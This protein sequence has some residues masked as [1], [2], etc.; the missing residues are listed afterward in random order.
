MASAPA[1]G[2]QLNENTIQS[3]LVDHITSPT[4]IRT[5][6]ILDKGGPTLL[7]HSSEA[8]IIKFT[9]LLHMERKLGKD[10]SYLSKS[11]T[12]TYVLVQSTNISYMAG[13]AY[14]DI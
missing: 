9:F 12:I 6:I 2:L 4:D 14:G 8:F 13:G 1:A 11:L 7:F 3:Y 5:Y 10:R